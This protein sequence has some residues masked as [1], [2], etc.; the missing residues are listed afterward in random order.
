MHRDVLYQRVSEGRRRRL[1]LNIGARGE[2]IFGELAGEIAAE[3]AVHF[4]QGDAPE[5]AI[6]HLRRAAANAAARFA[7][8]PL[9]TSSAYRETASRSCRPAS[10]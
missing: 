5:R 10:R 3:L 2:E 9:L 1:H 7:N 6:Q 8:P 4:E